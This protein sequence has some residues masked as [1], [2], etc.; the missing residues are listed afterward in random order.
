MNRVSFSQSINRPHLDF[1][2]PGLLAGTVGMIV[3]QGAIGKSFLAL[4]IGMSVALGKD[5]AGGLWLAPKPGACTICFGEDPEPILQERQHW[6]MQHHRMSYDEAEKVDERLFSYSCIGDDMRI[7]QRSP[8]GMEDGPFLSQV[9]QLAEG[10]RLL[11]LDPLLFLQGGE[12]NDN[13]V[14][15]GLMQRLSAVARDTGCAIIVLHHVGKGGGEGKEE[16]TAARGA[17]AFTTSVR[18]QLNMRPPTPKEQADFAI[19]DEMRRFWIRT[20]VVKS[21]YGDGG[22]EKWL[23]RGQG[24]TLQA[25]Q[26][27]KAM[28][29]ATK[30]KKEDDDDWK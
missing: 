28:S 13:N 11:I 15:A 8:A 1:V 27:I 4:E 5:V 18:W 23:H 24:G 12:E 25:E 20:A 2:L 3:G 16:W 22:E 19:D 6:L 7:V 14:A 29:K 30:G 26:P 21:N 17:S 10:S 9:R